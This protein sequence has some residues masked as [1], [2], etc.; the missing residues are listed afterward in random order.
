MDLEDQK[1]LL[2]DLPITILI[3]ASEDPIK[4]DYPQFSFKD[5]KKSY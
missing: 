4:E 1:S 3:N 2:K 5:I